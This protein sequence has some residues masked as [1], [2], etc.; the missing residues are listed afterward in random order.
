MSNIFNPQHKIL[1]HLNKVER[2]FKKE[3]P[4]PI[5]IEVDPSNT[6][7]HSCP[8]CISGHLHLKKFKGTKYFNRTILDKNT[9]KSLIQDL[10]K[11]DIEA[12]NWTGGGEPTQNPYLGEAIKYINENSN[13][14]MGMFTNGTLLEKMKLTDVVVDCLKW[15][16]ISIDA[17]NAKSYNKLRVTN[18]SNDFDT[19]I[20]NIKKIIDMKNKKN[21]KIT[22]GVGFIVTQSNYNEIL[23]F[24]KIFKDI[25]VDY[26]QYKPE[27]IQIE[28]QQIENNLGNV[29]ISPDFWV[30]KVVNLLDEAKSILGDKFECNGYKI[31]DLIIDVKKYG[32]NYKECIGS[33]F[34][35][36]IGA[37]GN[38]YVCTNH[39][40]HKKYSYGN[41][42]EKT[43][44]EIWNDLSKRKKIMDI[45]NKKEKFK[46]CTHLCKPHE[47]NKILWKI[48]ENQKDKKYFQELQSAVENLTKNTKHKNFI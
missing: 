3:N 5:T 28:R 22:I 21:S 27:I 42:N 38:V 33:Q 44:R 47:S 8:F 31:D 26:C 7:N 13:I 19:V 6:C 18:K 45:I 16:R 48:K 37:D 40:G 10:V 25:D 9:F 2:Y 34:Q 20:K 36:C 1:C 29:Q 11:I 4:Y 41:I 35:P 23:E 39:R 43:F 24:A 32:R 30:K 12:I 14:E 17:G 15:I 46:N